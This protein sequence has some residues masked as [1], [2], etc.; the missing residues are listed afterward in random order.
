MNSQRNNFI[1]HSIS[2]SSSPTIRL[3][4]GLRKGLFLFSSILF[5]GNTAFILGVHI[6]VFW[7]AVVGRVIFGFGAGTWYVLVYIVALRFGGFWVRSFVLICLLDLLVGGWDVLADESC[8]WILY[9]QSLSAS[10]MKC[11]LI[12][13]VFWNFIVE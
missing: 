4:P 2:L 5:L 13:V 8:I 9:W 10:S 12:W 7:L 3:P 6:R 1:H 11:F